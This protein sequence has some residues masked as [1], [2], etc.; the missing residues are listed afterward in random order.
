MKLFKILVFISQERKDSWIKLK[1]MRDFFTF[2]YK[3]RL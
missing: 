1:L 3:V 2:E